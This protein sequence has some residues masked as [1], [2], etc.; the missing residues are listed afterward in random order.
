M[1]FVTRKHVDVGSRSAPT[2][3][4]SSRSP[5]M[6]SGSVDTAT[7][8]ASPACASEP[9]KAGGTLQIGFQVFAGPPSLYACIAHT[10][11]LTSPAC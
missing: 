5:T 3:T 11:T 10:D 7:A 9:G 1:L 8:S 6:V 2:P 4:W